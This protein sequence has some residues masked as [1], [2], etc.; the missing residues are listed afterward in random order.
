MND[1]IRL[2]EL[3]HFHRIKRHHRNH[4]GKNQKI[5]KKLKN[6]NFIML[7]FSNIILTHNYYSKGHS[8][9]K[10]DSKGL[11]GEKYDKRGFSM[12]MGGNSGNPYM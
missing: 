6:K 5:R 4:P 8:S 7:T 2:T 9:E 3:H 10:Y 11:F 12:K 1:A